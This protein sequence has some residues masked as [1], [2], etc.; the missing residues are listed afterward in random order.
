MKHTLCGVFTLHCYWVVCI[1]S[2]TGKMPSTMKSISI[3]V[4]PDYRSWNTSCGNEHWILYILFVRELWTALSMQCLPLICLYNQYHVMQPPEGERE[5]EN[6]KKRKKER[7]RESSSELSCIKRLSEFTSIFSKLMHWLCLYQLTVEFCIQLIDLTH[8]PRPHVSLVASKFYYGTGRI[9]VST[10]ILNTLTYRCF[11]TAHFN[12]VSLY[13]YHS[14]LAVF[15]T[16]MPP[17]LW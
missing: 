5:R 7:N 3:I 10:I 4:L 13:I 16:A 12:N 1:Q 11:K 15:N 14:D 17:G 6:K 2:Q 8:V 9:N